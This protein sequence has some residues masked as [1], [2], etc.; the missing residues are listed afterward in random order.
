MNGAIIYTIAVHFNLVVF[1]T[2]NQ[3]YIV[4]GVISNQMMAQRLTESSIESFMQ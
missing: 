4:Q 2:Q 3:L 1:F